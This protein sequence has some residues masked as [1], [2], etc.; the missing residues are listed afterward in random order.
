MPEGAGPKPYRGRT[1]ARPNPYPKPASAIVDPG[2]L[3][4]MSTQCHERRRFLRGALG[5]AVATVSLPSGAENPFAP[6]PLTYPSLD[7][8]GPGGLTARDLLNRGY[9][10]VPSLPPASGQISS[11]QIADSVYLLTGAGCNAIAVPTGGGALLIDGGL[12]AHAEA[13]L[14]AVADLPG[15]GPVHTLF[16]TSWRP[17]YRG[18][19]TILGPRGARIIAHL[20]ASDWQSVRVTHPWDPDNPHP[21]LPAAAR[22]NDTLR[23]FDDA[24]LQLDIEGVTV[25][26]ARLPFAH[27]DS[28]LYVYL[29][30]FDVIAIGG[31]TNGP[32]SSWAQIDYRGNWPEIDW[33]TGGRGN[34]IAGALS[35]I[36]ERSGSDTVVV[37]AQGGLLSP[38]DLQT[39]RT[40]F[41][42]IM[43]GTGED[44]IDN[45]YHSGR[46]GRDEVLARF[47]GNEARRDMIRQWGDPTVF[48]YRCIESSW[49]TASADA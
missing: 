11:R 4:T 15:S 41:Q 21:A 25:R 20:L 9:W 32:D 13:L 33:W 34:A 47:L 40:M 2:I 46:Y 16:N 37:P 10:P 8:P 43:T 30:E 18:A 38:S 29:P 12:H 19:N 44:A 27:T 39:Q 48:V 26:F 14:A 1:R 17:E 22:A 28:S 6:P 7:L 45:V 23:N 5:V 31:V 49:P 24:E 35:T 42:T 36:I 3:S